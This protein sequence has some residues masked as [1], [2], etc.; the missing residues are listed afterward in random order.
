MKDIRNWV[1]IT[2]PRDL[3]ENEFADHVSRAIHEMAA[4][5]LREVGIDVAEG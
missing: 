4:V 5:D 1:A 3:T 2:N